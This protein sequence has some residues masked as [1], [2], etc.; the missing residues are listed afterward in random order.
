MTFTIEAIKD[1]HRSTDF[2]SSAIV[3]VILARKRVEDG[4]AVSITATSGV[5]ILPIS[6]TSC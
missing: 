4:V 5:Y 2:R 1:H 3:A 6:S